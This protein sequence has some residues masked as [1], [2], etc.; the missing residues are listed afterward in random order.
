M[1]NF[2]K[3][4]K[5]YEIRFEDDKELTA[6]NPKWAVVSPDGHLIE[7][8]PASS[9][10]LEDICRIIDMEENTITIHDISTDFITAKQFNNLI[11]ILRDKGILN[12]MDIEKIYGGD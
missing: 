4:Y 12:D 6:P 2:V 1:E 11:S 8:Y 7:Y 10:T 3:E 5:G 9:Y